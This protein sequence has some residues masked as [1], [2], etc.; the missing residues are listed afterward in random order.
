LEQSL[1]SDVLVIKAG[2]QAVFADNGELSAPVSRLAS[3]DLQ[4]LL[5]QHLKGQDRLPESG[6]L[7]DLA[8][9]E[10]VL[11]TE[12]SGVLGIDFDRGATQPLSRTMNAV[13]GAEFSPAI[14]YQPRGQ[15]WKT[16][17]RKSQKMNNN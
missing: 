10:G 16:W 7:A 5:L 6:L 9:E 1:D 14:K 2:E 8:E 13:Y 4:R 17:K 11:D 15:S 3:T 12:L